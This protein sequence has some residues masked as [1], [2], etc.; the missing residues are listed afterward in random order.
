MVEPTQKVTKVD[1]SEEY[2]R[3]HGRDPPTLTYY[4]YVS[5]DKK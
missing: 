2:K 5:W 1:M 4:V 3:V